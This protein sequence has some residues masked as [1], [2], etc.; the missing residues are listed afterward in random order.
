MGNNPSIYRAGTKERFLAAAFSRAIIAANNP[1]EMTA[2]RM[3]CLDCVRLEYLPEM[4][5]ERATIAYPRAEMGE[6][7][8]LCPSTVN[9]PTSFRSMFKS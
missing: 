1:A 6:I 3:M 7:N 9:L 2:A 5:I 8:L 4:R